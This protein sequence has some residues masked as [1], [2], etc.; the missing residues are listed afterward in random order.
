MERSLQEVLS[1]YW[2]PT[3]WE[4]KLELNCFQQSYRDNVKVCSHRCHKGSAVACSQSQCTNYHRVC[5]LGDQKRDTDTNGDHGEGC[6]AVAH[7]HGEEGHGDTVNGGCC[8]Q[9]AG[10][11]DCADTVCDDIADACCGEQGTKCSQNLRQD[12]GDTDIVHQAGSVGNCVG[13]LGLKEQEC[14]D[15]G[16]RTGNADGVVC[17]ENL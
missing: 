4:L 16:D 17:T 3:N 9:V 8:E 6:K 14:Y 1:I 7:D 10:R 11:D 12:A 15:Q 5:A 13:W 2:R